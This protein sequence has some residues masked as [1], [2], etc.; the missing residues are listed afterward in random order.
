MTYTHQERV[1]TT[2]AAY[3]S[4]T[5]VWMAADGISVDENYRRWP[6]PHKIARLPVLI[7]P[8]DPPPPRHAEALIGFGGSVA[9]IALIQHELTL[10]HAPEHP[11]P[12][13]LYRWAHHV[14]HFP[15][16][17]NPNA[18]SNTIRCHGSRR[19]PADAANSIASPANVEG[20]VGTA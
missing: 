5:T 7:A 9:L 8:D 13:N 1:L 15:S 14:A 11:D 17:R 16:S 2:I 19:R 20:A 18:P 4:G 6:E 12:H 10:P 3:A